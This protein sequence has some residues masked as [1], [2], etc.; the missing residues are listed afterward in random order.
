MAVTV[1]V[2][3]EYRNRRGE[4]VTGT[5]HARRCEHF[6]AALWFAQSQ[7]RGAVP[8]NNGYT[9]SAR[10]LYRADTGEVIR[11]SQTGPL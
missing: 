8:S 9:V 1:E 4:Y 5:Y 11:R 2:T 3:T 7:W 10:Y 6:P